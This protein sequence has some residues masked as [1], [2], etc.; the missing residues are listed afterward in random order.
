MPSG[1]C[2]STGTKFANSLNRYSHIHS[3]NHSQ[4]QPRNKRG[5][6]SMMARYSSDA[7]VTVAVVEQNP[8]EREYLLAL[9]AG[10]P[11]V[12]LSGA[13]SDLAEAL[14][15]IRKDPPNMVIADL[16][17]PADLVA[18]M[19]R[20]LHTAVPHT[21]VLVLPTLSTLSTLVTLAT[22]LRVLT[23]EAAE[24]PSTRPPSGALS[25][26]APSSRGLTS[27]TVLRDPGAL[28][29]LMESLDDT[30]KLGPGDKITYRVLEDQD[31]TAPLVVSDAGDVDVPYLGL[32]QAAKKSC[33]QLALTIKERL[34]KSTYRRATVIVSLQ[35]IN[36]KRILGK[37]YVV[38]QV[39]QSGPQE[40]PDDEVFTVSKVILKAGGFSDFADKH[41]VRLIHGGA[42]NESATNTTI[43]NIAE[44]W[45][46]GKT[47]NDVPVEAD[48]LVYVPKR[49][50]NF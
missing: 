22:L 18:A 7:T 9:V 45:E 25:N 35:E 1:G 14:P 38:G 47:G 30:K 27:A 5:M 12:T 29:A 28:T 40:I 21:S 13:Y 19:L 43:I 32:V 17:G 4:S 6:R 11:G 2:E 31:E 37:V 8:V 36:R 26:A 23:V 24:V 42:R 39:R 33:K 44:I 48:D 16:E 3:H 49:S 46:K 20:Q 50:V 34:E 41:K 10:A 15:K